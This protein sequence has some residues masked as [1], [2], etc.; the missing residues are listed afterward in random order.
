RLRLRKHGEDELAHYSVGCTDIEYE[1]PFG[2]SEL[3]GIA[4]RTDFDLKQHAQFSGKDLKYKD[5]VTQEEVIPFVIEPSGG[6]DRATLAFLVDAYHEEQ[7]NDSP[8]VVLRFHKKLAPIKVAVLPLLKKSSEIVSKAKAIKAD[9]QKN[10]TCVYD[11]TASIGKLYRRQ[12]EVGTVL[13][14][15]V[16]PESLEDQQVTVRERDSMQQVRIPM[17][18]LKSYVC[19]H[20]GN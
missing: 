7:V 14:V 4:N 2:W 9:L 1:F 10:V 8:R 17:D 20:F 6:V 3:E 19:E 15:T 13:C 16:D 5:S 12:D 18:R 11:D